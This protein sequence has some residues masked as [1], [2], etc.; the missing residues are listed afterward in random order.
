MNL[1]PL[2]FT[3]NKSFI[4]ILA[5]NLNLIK[6]ILFT[7]DNFDLKKVKSAG[8]ALHNAR[9]KLPEDRKNE[10]V[11]VHF[12]SML[13]FKFYPYIFFYLTFFLTKGWNRDNIMK[14]P[15]ICIISLNK[16]PNLFVHFPM[17][18]LKI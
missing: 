9:D 11:Q 1:L 3:Q 8:R 2:L 4:A 17:E 12:M 7:R 16:K 14:T 10:L 15:I 18:Y 5:Y 6:S 13:Q